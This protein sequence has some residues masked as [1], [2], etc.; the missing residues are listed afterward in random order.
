VLVLHA[1][2]GSDTERLMQALPV[3]GRTVLTLA[4]PA[5]AALV[6]RGATA[7]ESWAADAAEWERRARA[8]R[9]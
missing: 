8:G 7:V 1:A 9:H 6:E 4:D 3:A 2:P 5:N